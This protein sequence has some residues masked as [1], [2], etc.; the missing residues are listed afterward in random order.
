MVTKW[1]DEGSAPSLRPPGGGIKAELRRSRPDFALKS[2]A[3]VRPAIDPCN[4]LQGI[5]AKPNKSLF[6]GIKIVIE[7]EIR[8]K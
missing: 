7:K 3:A 5:L 8:H 4:K 6:R 2:Y 1:E